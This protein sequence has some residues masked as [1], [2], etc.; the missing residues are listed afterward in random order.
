MSGICRHCWLGRMGNFVPLENVRGGRLRVSGRLRC[1]T[2][3]DRRHGRSCR[4]SRPPP[5]RFADDRPLL[6][7]SLRHGDALMGNQHARHTINRKQPDVRCRSRAEC[8]STFQRIR[9]LHR[10]DRIESGISTF[11]NRLDAREVDS[12]SAGNANQVGEQT[13][14]CRISRSNVW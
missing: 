4:G 5:D 12:R 2:D 9:L 13:I 8:V 10:D 6:V 7:S 14:I 11:P 1:S 3:C